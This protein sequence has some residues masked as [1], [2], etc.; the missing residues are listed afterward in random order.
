MQIHDVEPRSL[1]R[2]RV[3]QRPRFRYDLF[4]FLCVVVR[5]VRVIVEV[6]RTAI[7]V[8]VVT[9]VVVEITVVTIV[10]VVMIVVGVPEGVVV[11]GVIVVMICNPADVGAVPQLRSWVMHAGRSGQGRQ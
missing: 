2:R 10:V 11:V 6:S 3:V 9:I 8:V 7:M 1:E 5:V 4:P